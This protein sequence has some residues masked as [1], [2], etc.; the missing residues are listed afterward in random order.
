MLALICILVVGA[1]PTFGESTENRRLVVVEKNGQYVYEFVAQSRDRSQERQGR[2][3]SRTDSATIQTRETYYRGPTSGSRKSAVENRGGVAATQKCGGPM[4]IVN[5]AGQCRELVYDRDFLHVLQT[6]GLSC[7]RRAAE[8]AFGFTPTSIKLRTGEGQ[9]SASR[10]SSNGKY[11]THSIGRALDIFEVDIYNG[12]ANSSV[13]MHR[14]HMSTRGHRTFYSEFG[15]C[16]REVVNSERGERAGQCGSGCLDYHYN[17]AHWDHM[18]L[19][20]PPQ[21]KVRRSHRVN[22]T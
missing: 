19:S 5:R 1:L 11:S 10:R 4:E 2:V 6:D 16:W 20:L 3:V 17:R 9:V 15:D 14:S 18:H 13:K 7:A 22:C 8:S 12:R 21:D